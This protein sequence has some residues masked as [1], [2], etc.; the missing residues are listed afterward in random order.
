M[1]KNK[2]KAM[3]AMSKSKAFKQWLRHKGWTIEKPLENTKEVIRAT[4]G[5]KLFIAYRISNKATNF[6]VHVM[7]ESMVKEFIEQSKCNDTNINDNYE[8]FWR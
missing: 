3:L 2:Y 5:D 6:S 8:R 7:Y 1:K 4:N